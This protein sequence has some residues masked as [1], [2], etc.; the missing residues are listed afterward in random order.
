MIRFVNGEPQYFYYSTHDGGEAYNFSAIEKTN[1]R[2][3]VYVATGSHASYAVSF[4][5]CMF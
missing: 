3:T 2:P 4:Y 1:G 5:T